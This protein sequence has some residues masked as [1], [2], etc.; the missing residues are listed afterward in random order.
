MRI[1]G[2]VALYARHLTTA[3]YTYLVDAAQSHDCVLITT[4]VAVCGRL[5]ICLMHDAGGTQ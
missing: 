5:S 3:T 2:R 1:A 4:P